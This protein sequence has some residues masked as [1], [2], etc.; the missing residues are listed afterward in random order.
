VSFARL[1]DIAHSLDLDV[2]ET[3][4]LRSEEYASRADAALHGGLRLPFPAISFS[5]Q[6]KRYKS[7]TSL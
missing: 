5:I 1:L 3:I 2:P 7:S 4:G 6:D